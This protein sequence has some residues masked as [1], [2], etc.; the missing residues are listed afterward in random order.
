MKILAFRGTEVH[1]IPSF[2]ILMGLFVILSLEN[3]QPWQE[4]LLWIPVIFVSVLFHEAGHAAAYGVLG[5]GPSLIVLG[6]YG[7]FT[8]NRRDRRAWQDVIVS[9]AGPTFSFL[10]AG[11]VF[12]LRRQVGFFSSDPMF[13]VLVPLLILSNVVWGIFNLIPVFPMDGG[14]AVYGIVRYLAKPRSALL[15]S[16][17]SS[18]VLGGLLLVLGLMSGQ[19]FVSIILGF[20][21]YQ[22]YQRLQTLG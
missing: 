17:W 1:A 14:Q 7:G 15:I 10:L 16:I 22:N 20:L 2:L 18:M 21:L 12:L 13:A 5:L 11:L 4:A 9:L 3:G 19:F 8:V 6:G